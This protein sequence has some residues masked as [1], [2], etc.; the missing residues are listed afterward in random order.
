MDI[1][2]SSVRHIPKYDLRLKITNNSQRYCHSI[3][4][5]TLF[6]KLRK[7]FLINYEVMLRMK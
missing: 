5:A 3:G 6:S 1:S 7:L 2:L 4:G